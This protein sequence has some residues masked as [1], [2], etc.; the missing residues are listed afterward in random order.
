MCGDMEKGQMF[1]LMAIIIIVVLVMLRTSLSLTEI[2]ENKRYLELGLERQKFKNIRDEAI[3]S[4]EIAYHNSGNMTENVETFL[5]FARDLLKVEV[6]DLNGI[7]ISSSFPNVTI[8]TDTRLNVSVLNFLG[9][10][11][12]N[13]NISFNSSSRNFTSVEDGK[14]IQTNFNFST[15]QN[16]NYTLT[17]YYKTAYEN[18][19]EEVLIPVEIG[20]SKFIEFFD[21]RLIS[22]RLEQRDK[23]TQTYTLP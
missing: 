3:R 23:F 20:K 12:I 8:N 14:S 10:S 16:V 1:L 13:L 22:S 11:L 6:T 17:V 7:I 2:I 4:V 15:D 9:T 19:T 5:R 18:K 21:L